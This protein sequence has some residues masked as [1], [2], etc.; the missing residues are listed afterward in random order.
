M[1]DYELII[2]I[3]AKGEDRHTVWEDYGWLTEIM[4]E[5]NIQYTLSSYCLGETQD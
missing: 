1:K 4:D 5:R 2:T 3:S